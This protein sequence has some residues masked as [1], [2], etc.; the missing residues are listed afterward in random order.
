MRRHGHDGAGAVAGEHVVG[1]P[2]W[3]VCTIDR[4]DCIRAGEDATFFLRG[5]LAV[6]LRFGRGFLDVFLHRIPLLLRGDLGHERMFRGE[7]HVG[8][9][10]ERVRSR[11]VDGDLG[12]AP[13]E[14]EVDERTLRPADP[15]FLQEF[16]RLGPVEGGQPIEQSIGE[17]G[18]PQYPLAHGSPLDRKSAD[19]AFP[20]DDL[21]VRQHGAEL[22]APVDRHL[23]DI[24]EAHAVGIIAAVGRDRLCAIGRGIEP[25]VVNLQK[26]PLR[27]SHVT[28]IGGVDLA[29]PVV[30][31]PDALQLLLE[32]LDILR[33]CHRRV[34]SGP[35][36]I[37]LGRKPERVPAH[38]MQ[39]VEPAHAVMARED[40]CRGVALGMPD[41]QALAAGVGEH[42]EHVVFRTRRIELGFTRVRRAEG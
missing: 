16:D 34:L 23:R 39:H 40:V 35:D 37:L 4:V 38:R 12:S 1:D 19:L 42:V 15:V 9:A 11:G 30:A 21:F 31:E 14:H 22:R 17:G 26:N 36:R 28:R 24:R 6:A 18:D 20:I 3:K 7:D 13:R 27:P 29:R 41:V 33:R 8:R 32:S 2:N 25:G 5:I 10:E